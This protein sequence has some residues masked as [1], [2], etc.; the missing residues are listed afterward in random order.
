MGCADAVDF[1][2]CWSLLVEILVVFLVI[3]G[4]VV[5]WL[6]QTGER[7]RRDWDRNSS[8]PLPVNALSI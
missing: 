7:R 8:S 5:L 6:F 1:A 4:V 2:P 3:G